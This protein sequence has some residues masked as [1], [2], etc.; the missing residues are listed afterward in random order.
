MNDS[1]DDDQT[2]DAIADVLGTTRQP[3]SPPPALVPDLNHLPP[4]PGDPSLRV[5]GRPSV[6]KSTVPSS[7]VPATMSLRTPP[8]PTMASEPVT[9]RQFYA[10]LAAVLAVTALL[11]VVVGS[12][13]T[14]DDSASST[15]APATTTEAKAT[16]TTASTTTPRPTTTTSPIV[17][18]STALALPAPTGP[19]SSAYGPVA[20]TGQTLTV[21]PTNFKP[22][23]GSVAWAWEL[24]PRGGR[25][26]PV[27]GATK[28]TF[29]VP[30]GTP[31]RTAVRVALDVI[32]SGQDGPIRVWSTPVTVIP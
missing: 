23:S 1:S 8:K 32:P 5:Q 4:P 26:A 3:T 25:C 21:P 13:F 24:C 14:S 11:A 30:K 16:T 19:L 6:G 29:T 15:P 31:A 27:P 10:G 22:K 20:T 2:L 12:T 9:Q 17:I 7:I 28:T 18:P